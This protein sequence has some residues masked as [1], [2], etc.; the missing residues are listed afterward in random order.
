MSLP[1]VSSQQI[2]AMQEIANKK[3]AEAQ[4]RQELAVEQPEYEQQVENVEEQVEEESIQEQDSEEV[5]EVEQPKISLKEQNLRNLRK[6]AERAEYERERAERAER[7]R[8]EAIKMAMS[9]KKHEVNPEPQVVEDDP[10]AQFSMEDDALVEGKQIK[11]L[12]RHVK[13]LNSKLKVYEQQSQKNSL[14]TL[15][16]KLQSQFP[17]FNE[18]VTQDNLVK[19]RNMNP[20]LAD[21]ILHNQDQYKQAKLAYDMVKQLGIYNPSVSVNRAL[22]QNNMT[23]PRSASS[24]SATKADSA[25]S[26]VN[27]FANAPLTKEIKEKHYQEMLEAMKGR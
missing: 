14:Q 8:D 9:F 24:L 26:R 15:E 23:K 4:N 16:M 18:V 21:A 1:M 17:D 13:S 25:I 3:M 12:V 6:Q 7:E 5:E 2:D 11:E 20:D 22:A 19:L 27:G 10:F